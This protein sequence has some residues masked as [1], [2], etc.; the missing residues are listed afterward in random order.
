[1]TST[2]AATR[3]LAIDVR[4]KD[5]ALL[6]VALL[7]PPEPYLAILEEG[8]NQP[9][10]VT[11]AADVWREIEAWAAAG[12]A[13]L[14]ARPAPMSPAI[15]AALLDRDRPPTIA[16]RIASIPIGITSPSELTSLAQRLLPQLMIARRA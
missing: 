9:K 4:D 15:V 12:D 2:A 7:V 16:Q 11:L 5:N 1:M 14:P 13:A 3:A 10:E 8:A 6:A